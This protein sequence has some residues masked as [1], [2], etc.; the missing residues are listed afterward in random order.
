MINDKADKVINKLFDLLKNR[1]LNNLESMKGSEF[2]FH[3]VHFFYYKCHKVNPNRGGPYIDSHDWIK[4][5]KPTI[6]RINKKD[7][8]CFQYAVAVTLNYDEIKINMNI[9]G[10]E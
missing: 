8:K 7:N 10:K 5:K 6:N 9:T 4:N 2:V 3:Y 1:Y